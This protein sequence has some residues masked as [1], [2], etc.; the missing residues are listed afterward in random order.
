MEHWFFVLGYGESVIRYGQYS[1]TVKYGM[2]FSGFVNKS[3]DGLLTKCQALRWGDAGNHATS[4]LNGFSYFISS[5][6]HVNR[7]MAKPC[8]WWH[9]CLFCSYLFVHTLAIDEYPCNEG[10]SQTS[11]AQNHYVRK[12]G[13]TFKR[14]KTCQLPETVKIEGHVSI[15]GT[16]PSDELV[17]FIGPGKLSHLYNGRHFSISG[18]FTLTLRWLKLQDGLYYGGGSVW[19]EKGGTLVTTNCWFFNNAV[20]Y[21]GAAISAQ[22]DAT[23]QL[24]DTNVSHSTYGGDGAIYIYKQPSGTGILRLQ[25]QGGF[26][27]ENKG[28]SATSKGAA[29]YCY[30]ATECLLNGTHIERNVVGGSGGGVAFIGTTRYSGN[31][32]SILNSVVRGNL[33]GDSG[34]GIYTQAEIV[35]KNSLFEGNTAGK[36]GGGAMTSCTSSYCSSTFEKTTF[37][38]NTA[39][40][41]GGMYV[42]TYGTTGKMMIITNNT[43][44]DVGGGAFFISGYIADI[45]NS[46]IAGNVAGNRGGGLLIRRVSTLKLYNTVIES[47]VANYSGGGISEDNGDEM[48]TY[49]TSFNRVDIRRSTFR[50]NRQDCG[51][52]CKPISCGGAIRTTC[53]T[54]KLE[55]RES[56]FLDNVATANRGHH[57]CTYLHGSSGQPTIVNTHIDDGDGFFF[58]FF[59]SQSLGSPTSNVYAGTKTC[60]SQPNVCS[61]AP[62]KGTCVARE[63]T[64]VGVVCRSSECKSPEIPILFDKDLPP[65]RICS[66]PA[67]HYSDASA[68]CSVC[69]A[70]R[71]TDTADKLVCDTCPQ[72][73]FLNDDGTVASKHDDITDC[74]ACPSGQYNDGIGRSACKDCGVGKYQTSM[75]QLAC[76]SCEACP[77]GNERIGCG[78]ASSGSCRGCTRGKYH[79]GIGFGQ[80]Q[81]CPDGQNNAPPF[82]SCPPSS[83][84]FR[85]NDV[86]FTHVVDDSVAKVD[87]TVSW[88]PPVSDGGSPIDGYEYKRAEIVGGKGTVSS[89]CQGDSGGQW[90]Y[91]NKRTATLRLAPESVH[92]FHVRAHNEAYGATKPSVNSEAL[93]INVPG[94]SNRI[95][96]TPEEGDDQ[97]C[98]PCDRNGICEMPCA[99][100]KRALQLANITGQTIIVLPGEYNGTGLVANVPGLVLKANSSSAKP[101]INCHGKPCFLSSRLGDGDTFVFP[102]VIDGF[103]FI[104]GRSESGGCMHIDQTTQSIAIKNCVFQNCSAQKYGGALHVSGAAD[105]VVQNSIFLHNV[106]GQ[107]GGG[108]SVISTLLVTVSGC[109]FIQ[110]HGASGGGIALITEAYGNTLGQARNSK[111]SNVHLHGST[112]AGNQANIMEG[113]ASSHSDGGAVFTYYGFLIAQ[114]CNFTS[115]LALRYGGAIF[116]ES[117][118]VEMTAINI[119]KNTA[120]DRNG[121]GG[122]VGCLSS[123]M[124]WTN[125]SI[126]HNYARGSGGGS[127]FTFCA[128]VIQSSSWSKNTATLDGGG[129]YF[130]MMSHPR[131][132]EPSW[133]NTQESYIVHNIAES[134]AGGGLYCFQCAGIELQRVVFQENEAKRGAGGCLALEQTR[135][136]TMKE[137]RFSKCL[138]H[139]GGGAIYLYETQK[140]SL[141]S[142]AFHHNAAGGGGGAI[143]WGFVLS[144]MTR[145]NDASVPLDLVDCKHDNNTAAY[146][147][148]VASSAHSLFMLDGPTRDRANVLLHPSDTR[149]RLESQAS[150]WGHTRGGALLQFNGRYVTIGILDWYNHVVQSSSDKIKLT[151]STNSSSTASLLGT[152]E[153]SAVG[154]ICVFDDLVVVAPPGTHVGLQAGSSITTLRRGPQLSVVTKICS[155]GKFFN[156]ESPTK[157]CSSCNSGMYGDEEGSQ[158]TCKTCE[159]GMYQG[160]HGQSVC[161]SCESGMYQ[162][163][164]KQ[165][166]CLPCTRGKFTD[167]SVSVKTEC[168]ECSAG[169]YGA[170]N[171]TCIPCEAGQFSREKSSPV[172][173]MCQAG[174]YT[175]GSSGRIECIKSPTPST[176]IIRSPAKISAWQEATF[177]LSASGATV[178]SFE[179]KLNN[180]DFE[181]VALP[182]EAQNVS[183]KLEGLLYGRHRFESRATSTRGVTGPVI[184]FYEWEIRHCN[185]P[186]RVPSTY[187][188]IATDGALECVACPDAEGANCLTL[189]AQWE[190]V[191]ANPGWWTAGT[192]DDTY[193]KCPLKEACPGGKSRRIV[194]NSTVMPSANKSQCAKGH[195]GVVCAVCEDGFYLLDN[196]CLV[197]LASDGGAV[198]VVV[199]TSLS[200]AGLF[201]ATLVMQLRVRDSRS[202]W[203]QL[204]GNVLHT[205]KQKQEDVEEDEK[206]KDIKASKGEEETKGIIVDSAKYLKGQKIGKNMKTFIGFV[207][208]LSVSDS[209]FEIPWP[210]GFLSFLSILVPFNFDFLSV[211]GIGCL[212]EYNFFHSF[213]GMASLP[214]ATLSLVYCTYRIGLACHNSK[215][216]HEF[217]DAMKRSY[218]N[219]AI[220]FTLWVVL[221]IYPPL[222]RRVVEYFACSNTIDGRSYLIK[223]YRILCY[224]G[225]WLRTLVLALAA[226]II[227]PFGIPAYFGVQLWKSRKRLQNPHVLARFGFLYSA[228]RPRSYLWDVFELLRKFFLT[229]GL[230]LIAPGS[231][232]QV[233][234]AVL[235]NLLFMVAL[236]V[237]TPHLPGP[238]RTLASATYVAIVFTMLIG[239]VLKTVD[240]A[241][242]HKLVFDILLLAI[243]LSVVVYTAKVL[244]TPICMALIERDRKRRHELS[245]KKTRTANLFL[246]PTTKIKKTT[247][248]PASKDNVVSDRVVERSEATIGLLV[249]GGTKRDTQQVIL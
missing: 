130:G 112:F 193:Y 17:A 167:E 177:L 72:G 74:F 1:N 180:G 169:T 142:V 19:V 38:M 172:C 208:I 205:R 222:S 204:Q 131:F 27:F 116:S 51:S 78:G 230:M 232:Y 187:A 241:S 12:M 79:T 44:S 81:S 124:Q 175:G 52:R 60:Q 42:G 140:L 127:W 215:F 71:F 133:E 150:D 249:H 87:V 190:D 7:M 11:Q 141:V 217:T 105:V 223:D 13:G 31:T 104:H 128:P 55:I 39:L 178:A 146:G 93:H 198:T 191:Y 153:V 89:S 235:F 8:K 47:N 46:I 5:R 34:G 245:L 9:V 163:N 36:N 138:A 111:K 173:V 174:Q 186:N 117:S 183:V 227:Y 149:D 170:V 233:A 239:L 135:L 122:G 62:Y 206:R 231:S 101:V 22:N 95:L 21:S 213:F 118:E 243:N 3:M 194:F 161:R 91:T 106:A 184:A 23:V 100:I 6:A 134:G 199:M 96:V 188:K 145:L 65:L 152:T 109:S 132:I 164:A 120:T 166:R 99:S 102:A 147:S 224:T 14:S 136:S 162:N 238:G 192:H 73:K 165:A 4:G 54:G 159:A 225:E 181:R 29:V 221:L 83:P 219:H 110:N 33:A 113:S 168:F 229:G 144:E 63:G 15:S 85:A 171:G 77:P 90:V 98:H 228:Y 176:H 37:T 200:V 92:S 154:G 66:C 237:H 94:R 32:F 35:I 86:L 50:N 212:V 195:R 156:A 244:C 107:V 211:S 242:N 43:A 203:N 69:S 143:L 137:S 41:G 119:L 236:L 196:K 246:N 75:G 226:V 2:T 49:Y 16:S 209:V 56:T 247:V 155:L 28:T 148:F 126:S 182:M 30:Y 26:F 61:Q 97:N 108:L 125:V 207:Q 82:S 197:C 151:T 123:F 53:T 201:F 216:A 160:E 58:G 103:Q 189:D 214:L 68:G 57:I 40:S 185:D 64:Y 80:C 218:T 84:T 70:G 45:D 88:N 76:H 248:V 18:E 129:L 24:V 114:E 59:K 179:W 20:Q 157:E 234:V 139:E 202:Y 121:G 210:D 67:G 25:V 158:K 240:A 115:N 220:Q 48:C 10:G